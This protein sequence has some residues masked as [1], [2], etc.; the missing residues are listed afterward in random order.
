MDIQTLFY[1]LA[2]IFMIIGIAVMLSILLFIWQLK[3]SA[4]AFKQKVNEKVSEVMQAKKFAGIIPIIGM[5]IKLAAERRARQ[6]E[7]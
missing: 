5:L 6:Q 1:F 7:S 2:S 4:E 3:T